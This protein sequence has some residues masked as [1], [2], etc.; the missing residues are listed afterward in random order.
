[1]LVIAT[2]VVCGT[3]VFLFPTEIRLGQVS[4]YKF[5]WEDTVLGSLLRRGASSPVVVSNSKNEELKDAK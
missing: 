1:M 4:K 5:W 2:I 3:I